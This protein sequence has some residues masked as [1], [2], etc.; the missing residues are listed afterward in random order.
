MVDKKVH[1]ERAALCDVFLDTLLVN[2]HT[3]GPFH[4]NIKID[5]FL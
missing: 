5:I 1:L 3:V 2:A 4:Y